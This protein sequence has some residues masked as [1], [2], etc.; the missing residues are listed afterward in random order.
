MNPRFVSLYLRCVFALVLLSFFLSLLLNVSVFLGADR[1]FGG[2]GKIL[3]FFAFGVSVLSFGLA[4]N[5]NVWKHEFKSCPRWLQI[6]TIVFMVYGMAIA[7]ICIVSFGE[8][9]PLEAQP[10]IASG[11]SFFIESMPICILYSLLWAAPIS[12]PELIKRIRVSVI[13]MAVLAAFFAA[14][15]FGYLPHRESVP[16]IQ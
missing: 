14:A 1:P 3:Y 2:Y 10:L 5:S 12:L 4:K 13:I 7:F 9:G 6:V 16:Q 15:H 11:F 8:R